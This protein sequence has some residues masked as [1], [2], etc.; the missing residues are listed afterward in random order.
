MNDQVAILRSSDE[1]ELIAMNGFRYWLKT[2]VSRP[3]S[4][5]IDLCHH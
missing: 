4:D 1:L 3:E 2:P 5:P